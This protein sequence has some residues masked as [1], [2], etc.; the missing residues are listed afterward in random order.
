MVSGSSPSLSDQTTVYACNKM[1]D[2]YQTPLGIRSF[3]FDS[4][5]G[6]FF[7]GK[8]MKIQG[9]CLHHDQGA[10]GTAVNKA[11]IRRQLK[12]LKEMGCNAIRT[13]HNPPAREL[14]DLCDD[15]GFLV[16]DEAFDMWKKKKNK[17]DYALDFNQWHQRDLEDQIKRDRNHPSVFMW[18]IGNEIREQFDSTGI[19]IGR[20]LVS[21]VKALDSTRPVTCALSEADPKKNFIYQSGALDVVGLNYHIETYADFL[22]IIPDKSSLAPKICRHWRA[23]VITICRRIACVIGLRVLNSKR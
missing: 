23:G 11:A 6:F 3:Y 14:L 4:Q 2:Q 9:V 12:I 5:K 21:I 10:L 19:S 18:S 13:S 20:A 17:F 8:P 7:N 16:M 22:K 15:M 1:I